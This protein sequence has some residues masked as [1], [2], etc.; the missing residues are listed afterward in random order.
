MY[1]KDDRNFITFLILNFITC[2]IYGIYFWYMYVEDINTVFYGDGEDSPNYILVLILSIITCGIYSFYWYY[3][4][5]S[6]IYRGAYDRYGVP[7]N[8]TGTGILLWMILGTLVCGLGIFVA[9]YFMIN[10]LNKVA[11]AY[12]YQQQNR[13]TNGGPDYY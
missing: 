12:N 3:K 11:Y 6:R 2:G 9:Q 4:Q 10:N 7:V 1:V 13:F 5:A 8:E